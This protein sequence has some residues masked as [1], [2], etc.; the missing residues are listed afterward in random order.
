MRRFAFLVAALALVAIAGAV[1]MSNAVS[2]VASWITWRAR[3]RAS[4]REVSYLTSSS[5]A[6]ALSCS[7]VDRLSSSRFWRSSNT[8]STRGSAMRDIR[9]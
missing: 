5:L 2:E 6:S 9:K 8:C 1:M 7:A 3:A 4:E